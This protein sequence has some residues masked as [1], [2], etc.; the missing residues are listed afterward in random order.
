MVLGGLLSLIKTSGG[1]WG[2][3]HLPWALEQ[4][5]ASIVGWDIESVVVLMK[6]WSS[7]LLL[8]FR[9]CV[10]W[11]RLSFEFFLKDGGLLIGACRGRG[12]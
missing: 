3:S 8:F 9:F 12:R 10:V 11:C 5:R 7:L 2:V 6:R 1:Q 4:G